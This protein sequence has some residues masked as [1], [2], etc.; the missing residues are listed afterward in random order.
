MVAPSDLIAYLSNGPC[1][2]QGVP[3]A[4]CSHS[5]KL[6]SQEQGHADL[7]L[8]FERC[9]RKSAGMMGQRAMSPGSRNE[10]AAWKAILDLPKQA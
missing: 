7:Y 6:R 3:S 4:S 5:I 8:P 9:P 2:G 1:S 10:P